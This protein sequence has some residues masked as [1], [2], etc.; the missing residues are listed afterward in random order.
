MRATTFALSVWPSPT[1]ELASRGLCAGLIGW[2]RALADGR[3]RIAYRAIYGFE[4]ACRTLV[5]QVDADEGRD[6]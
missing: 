1:P 6:V 5:A 2:Y 4:R 3:E